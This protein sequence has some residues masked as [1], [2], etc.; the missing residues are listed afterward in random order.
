[1]KSA[2]VEQIGFAYA[3]SPGADQEVNDPVDRLLVERAAHGGRRL[4]RRGAGVAGRRI[5]SSWARPSRRPCSSLPPPPLRWPTALPS[6]CRAAA[7]AIPTRAGR[8]APPA[9]WNPPQ[10]QP[11]PPAPEPPPKVLKPPKEEPKKG[12]PEL[13]SRKKAKKADKP[14]PRHRK[15]HRR[16]GQ[17]RQRGPRARVGPAARAAPPASPSALRARACP[18]AP[19]AGATGTSPACSRRSGCIWTQQIKTGFNEPIGVTFTILADG[20]VTD[21]Q[22]TEPERR[23]PS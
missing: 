22:V 2:G 17:A 12:L 14:A 11:E 23:R 15:A 8:Q 16:Q 4:S 10:P 13:D 18:R 9:A 3:A 7:A 20:S 6:C 19:T 1:M 21:V 5:S